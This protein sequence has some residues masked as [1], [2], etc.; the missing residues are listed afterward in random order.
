MMYSSSGNGPGKH[1]LDCLESNHSVQSRKY[2]KQ[3]DSL[4]NNKLYC[5]VVLKRGWGRNVQLQR[6]YNFFSITAALATIPFSGT[7]QSGGYD[8]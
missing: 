3:I 6:T 8:L 4:W 5:S 2:S 1:F 7:V